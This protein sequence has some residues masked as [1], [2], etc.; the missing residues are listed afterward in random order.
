ML[1]ICVD[2]WPGSL[3]EDEVHPCI[4]TH[5]LNQSCAN[6]VRFSN[7]YSATPVCI[8][9]RRALM[10]GITSQRHGDRIF[11]ERLP[12]EGL[13]TLAQTF[14]DAGY[15]TYAVGKLHVYPQRSRIGFDD[16]TLFE[17]GRHHL[18]FKA[19][20]Y[21]L[22][23]MDAGYAGQELTHAMCNNEYT[24]RPWHLPE[25]FHP[26]NWLTHQMCRTVKRRDPNRPAFWYL[27]YN[28]PHP[29]IVPIA[30]YP[31][32]YADANVPEPYIGD[33]AGDFETLPYALKVRRDRT[34]IPKPQDLRRARQGFYAQCTYIDHQLRLVIGMLREEE[35]LDNTIILFTC[36]HGDMLGN[37][38]L[39]AKSIF[40]EDSCRIPF[41]LVPTADYAN[42]GHHQVDDRLVELMDVMPT[43]LN[44][45]GI[46]IPDTVEGMSL[47]GNQRRDH[48][49]GEQN[50]GDLATRMLRDE[51]YKLIY[52]AVG[53]RFQLFDMQEG[54]Q[55]L[56]DLSSDP[57]HRA[58]C[59]GLEAKLIPHLYGEDLKWVED[60]RLVGLPDKMYVPA[61]N[62]GLSGQRGWRFM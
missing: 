6:G 22:A 14:S 56:Y 33:W 42:F 31:D 21:E 8:P 38:G 17:E 10:S 12:M 23:L 51:R 48:L 52:Y 20:D 45:A 58:I 19:D 43:L 40:Y 24:V 61:P 49:Y 59:D 55:E 37:H 57:A 62:R 46:P 35:L 29:P 16:V 2:H 7:A 54:R 9:A 36:D 32:M 30:S 25:H 13:T 34:P 27:S 18:G 5:T 41:I 53:N 4:M 15:Q 28:H 60:G 11:N 44:M 39:Y 3:L 47:M 50:Q 26:T 1:L